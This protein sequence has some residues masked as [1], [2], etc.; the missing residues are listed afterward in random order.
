MFQSVLG[1]I[2][3][4]LSMS[5]GLPQPPAAAPDDHSAEECWRLV[6]EAYAPGSAIYSGA[7]TAL[8]AADENLE[9]GT[10]ASGA[11]VLVATPAGAIHF[12]T[13]HGWGWMDFDGGVLRVWAEGDSAYLETT[14]PESKRHQ[15][16]SDQIR[17]FDDAV[18]WEVATHIELALLLDGSIDSIVNARPERLAMDDAAVVEM[19]DANRSLAGIFGAPALEAEHAHV[20]RFAGQDRTV[21]ALVDERTHRIQTWTVECS[22]AFLSGILNGP[23]F[24]ATTSV[25]RAKSDEP[26]AQERD[27][28]GLEKIETVEWYRAHLHKRVLKEVIENLAEFEAQVQMMEDMLPQIEAALDEARQQLKTLQA[29]PPRER[30]EEEITQLKWTIATQSIQV[31]G[32]KAD[33]KRMKALVQEARATDPAK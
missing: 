20:L 19:L 33:L 28:A 24:S 27:L 13:D 17:A 1:V 18:R 10:F 22:P 30:D 2:V 25:V 6:C 5:V 14:A 16:L 31:D 21:L 11:F 32:G 7:A 9:F 3:V 26:P 8:N 4:A 15:W 29:A 12:D 23:R